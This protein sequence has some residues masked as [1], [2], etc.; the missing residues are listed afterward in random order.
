[1]KYLIESAGGYCHVAW[2]ETEATLILGEGETA[3]P[4][5]DGGHSGVDAGLRLEALRLA[6]EFTPEDSV[7]PLYS[8][9]HIADEML[10]WLKKS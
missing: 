9:F 7:T 10:D 1:M 8:V 2:A 4:L 5:C 3:H 6:V